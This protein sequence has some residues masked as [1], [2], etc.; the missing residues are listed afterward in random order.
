MQQD[1]LADALSAINN[2]RDIGQQEVIIEPASDLIK[3]V[4]KILQQEEYIGLF[5]HIEDG[6]AG[7]FKVELKRTLNDCNAIKPRFSVSKDGYQKYEKRYLP[8]RGFGH[9]LVSTPEGVMTHDQA[10][11]DG[12]GGRL[13]G[14]VY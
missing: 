8:A 14:Y 11:E 7:K 9:L 5:E 4:L 2:A 6:Q 1:V 13:L 3:N 12:H 10:R